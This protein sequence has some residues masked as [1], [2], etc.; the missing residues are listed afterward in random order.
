MKKK[1]LLKSIFLFFIFLGL[2]LF[3]LVVGYIGILEL[4]LPNISVLKDVHLQVPLRILTNDN[5]LI[6]EFGN[7]RRIPVK[8]QQIPKKII[9]A[10][11]ATEDQRFYSHPG[12]DFIG[13]ARAALVLFL[14][15]KKKQ[16]AS[17][18]TMQVARNFF[19][20]R[21][22]T[23]YRK[24]REILLALEIDRTLSKDKVLE[25]YFNKI[26][27]GQRAYGIAAAAKVYYGK[28]LQELTL[29]QIAMLVGLPKAPT[30]LNPINHPKAALDRRDHVL[31]RLLDMHNIDKNTYQKAIQAPITASYH[32]LK[33]TVKA[34]YVAEMVRQIILKQFGHKAYDIGLNVYTTINGSLQTIGNKALEN[35]LLDYDQRHGYRGAEQ[36][37]SPIDLNNLEPI[38]KKLQ[39][40]PSIND[41]KPAVVLICNDQSASVLLKD[42]QIVTVFWK[43]M[44]W[45]RQQIM[46]D[47]QEYLGPKPQ[48]VS[49]ILKVGDIIRVRHLKKGIW[50]LSQIPQAESAIVALNPKN[51]AILAL[52]GGFNF[53]KSKFNRVI[54][55]YRQPGSSFKPFIYSAALAKGFTLASVIND[56]PVVIAD[57]G[58]N[59]IWRPENDTEKF[60]GPT[61]LRV[62]LRTSRN[63]VS[64]RLLQLIGIPYA[65][66]YVT[67]FGFQADRLPTTLSLALGSATVTPLQMASGYSV[68][69]NGGYRIK[70]YLIQ[71]IVNYNQKIIYQ[72][73]PLTVPNP[74]PNSTEVKKQKANL[75][76]QKENPAQRVITKQNDYLMVSALKD[77]IKHGTGQAAL[78][79]HRSDLAGKTGTT[80]LKKDAWFCG[81]N[82]N[83]V[84]I[85]WMGFDKPRPLYEYAAKAVLPMWIDFMRAALTGKPE[86]NIPQPNGIVVARIDK[87]TGLLAPAGDKNSRF[88]FFRKQYL[89]KQVASIVPTKVQT[90]DELGEEGLY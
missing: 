58:A 52:R 41:L 10:T 13:M 56:A 71:K 45:A 53:F 34:P 61:R 46:R 14:T 21:K 38:L 18:I 39:K 83:L 5:Q 76:Q 87:K 35:A 68:F 8:L 86:A 85:T 62:A 80:N 66:D 69:A 67:R 17:T 37:F 47:S 23:Y 77:V 44:F 73:K 90:A 26:F 55:A 22:K 25:L 72:A 75:T 51:G 59:A 40:I 88:E 78:V 29:P 84:A 6:A 31:T 81:F 20:S 50:A 27:Y 30:A 2:I 15:G 3:L 70:P 43:N 48:Q 19:L 7:V 32:D 24:I 49:D 1:S 63:L 28:T 42:G 16:G 36:N 74:N 65:I 82:P 11:I 33:V 4:K 64:I 9:Q 89:P 79:L 54:Q 60:Y 12:V 57:N